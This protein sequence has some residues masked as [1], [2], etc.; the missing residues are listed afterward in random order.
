MKPS[1]WLRKAAERFDAGL[2]LGPELL[3]VDESI[4]VPALAYIVLTL[5]RVESPAG[6]DAT[7]VMRFL[8]AA[9]IAESEGN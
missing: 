8:L 3:H 1:E 6:L 4:R 5:P 9:A 2:S 7:R